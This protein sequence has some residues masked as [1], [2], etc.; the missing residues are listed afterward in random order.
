VGSSYL[1]AFVSAGRVVEDDARAWLSNSEDKE[2]FR[3][4]LFVD[5]GLGGFRPVQD[6]W[7]LRL[8][9]FGLRRSLLGAG[10]GDVDWKLDAKAWK[11]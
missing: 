10:E 9:G 11:F 7:A 4:N 6:F 8:P 3:V 2:A 1:A 5:G